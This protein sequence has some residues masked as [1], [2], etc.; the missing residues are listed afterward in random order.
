[1][2]GAPARPLGIESIEDLVRDCWIR[3]GGGHRG[4]R[5]RD[6]PVVVLLGRHGS[7]KTSVLEYLAY[8]A[9]TA[10]VAGHDFASYAL[11]PHEVAARLAFRL[12]MR[13]THQPRLAFPRLAHG[14]VAADP[15]LRLD[16]SR[17]GQAR[18][19][20]AKAT[21]EARRHD[22]GRPLEA[23]SEGVGLLND[24]NIVPIPGVG[25]LA[26]LLLRGLG[27][28]VLGA[29]SQ[30]GL[31]WY[32]QVGGHDPL[33]TLAELNQRAR[34]EDPADMEWV[35]RLLCEAFLSDLR[36]AY[37]SRT[38]GA[39]DRNCLVVLDNIDHGGGTRFLRLVLSVREA[40]AVADG[41]CDPLLVVATASTARAVPGP[42]D[43]GPAGLR[44]RE[45]GRAGYAD[46]RAGVPQSPAD[47]SWWWYSVRLPDLTAGQVSQLGVAV[48][49]RLPEATPLVHRLTYGHP[50]SVVRMQR[51]VARMIDRPDADTALRGILDSGPVDRDAP[52]R[53]TLRQEAL[54]YLFQSTQPEHL[55]G[56]VTCAAARDM[57]AAVNSPLLDG[58]P[59]RVREKLLEEA[60]ERLCL[61]PP[62]SEDAGTRGGRGSGYLPVTGPAAHPHPLPDSPVLQPWLWQL[63]LRELA[64]RGPQDPYPDWDTAHER[65]YD[66]HKGRDGHLLDT[67]YHQLA[68][69]RLEEVVSRLDASL[70]ALPTTAWLY[71]LYA[72]TAAPMR[73]PV[74]VAVTASQRADR[75]AGELA[76]D[77]FRRNR[78]LTLLVTALWLAAD[79]RN[80]LPSA[81]PELNF[82]ISATFR[83]LALHADANGAVL[84]SEAARYEARTA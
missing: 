34:S 55:Q 20:L 10:P 8:R 78:A 14:L 22:V 53:T 26:T 4:R 65:L 21:K 66:W 40:L 84:R 45:A 11:R 52:D 16:T 73:E 29:A 69:G 59:G 51:A 12:S 3:P 35:D 28:R 32:A 9:S 6:L 82:T 54:H 17:P 57:D 79:P 31:D 44:I 37:D 67:H 39:R 15:E 76:P 56:L 36:A 81:Q 23:L 19:Q 50:W 63:L 43:P 77:G 83:D 74:D 2:P 61:V 18:R 24:F 38:G 71:E 5:G 72:I 49:P 25:L 70:R 30:A 60:A 7:G 1:M 62:L 42:F 47:A 46:W 68:L 64:G 13:T 27:P 75:L 33:D 41:G 58:F 80:R 48:A